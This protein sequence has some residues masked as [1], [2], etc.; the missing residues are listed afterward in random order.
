MRVDDFV[1]TGSELEEQSSSLAS[2]V[3]TDAV[4]A[5]IVG[6]ADKSR[7]AL[8]RNVLEETRR[9]PMGH[10]RTVAE[11]AT[12]KAGNVAKEVGGRVASDRLV[13]SKLGDPS[14]NLISRKNIK[15]GFRNAAI[16]A[17]LEGSEFEDVD[18]Y[19]YRTKAAAKIGRKGAKKVATTAKR[20][21]E[22]KRA[23]K[24]Q[25]GT[26]K[27]KSPA[28]VLTDTDG[29]SGLGGLSEKKYTQKK[30]PVELQRQMQSIRNQHRAMLATNP[31]HGFV[32]PMQSIGAKASAIAQGAAD[33]VG[34][35]L[36][37][38]SGAFAPAVG[39]ALVGLLFLTI[40][41]GAV[42]GSNEGN[43]NANVDGLAETE[44]EIT[45]TLSGYGFTNEAIAAILGNFA[46]ESGG[47]NHIRANTDSDDGYGTVSLGVMQMTGSERT[48]FLQWASKNGKDW[49][50][51]TT[52]MEWAFSNKSGTSSGYFAN[53][54]SYSWG[55]SSWHGYECYYSNER[56]YEHRFKTDCLKTGKDLIKTGD[57]DLAVY[58]WMA[59]YERPGSKNSSRY[60]TDVSRLN[61]RLSYA[62]KYLE[63]INS[64]NTSGGSGADYKSAS[65]AQKKIADQCKKEPS[66][67]KGQCA[68]WTNNVYEHATGKRPSTNANDE[69]FKY[70]KSSNKKD[71]KVGML[72]ASGPHV[73]H[74]GKYRNGSGNST[75]YGHIG[76]Y[77][78]DNKVMHSTGGSVHTDSLD[79]WIKSFTV[80]DV[81]CNKTMTVKWGFPDWVK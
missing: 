50:S 12:D 81:S 58:S 55:S 63:I 19:Y 43:T 45:Q 23:K 35:I 17:A 29:P 40:I 80:K 11:S 28:N 3:A 4:S 48:R 56:G 20:H 42:G 47:F 71:L 37:T 59:C 78:G 39:T 61:N 26:T 8:K 27:K 34:S 62:H 38:L 64:G 54:W 66:T 6:S 77:V 75:G 74:T 7:M 25:R 46:Q 69:Y 52:Q 32:G 49:K 33:G 30:S 36:G 22:K 10:R 14:E 65:K 76:I 72:I 70:C 41:S 31:S 16:G 60:N 13:S 18:T 15:A 73:G 44:T 9:N 68:K 21:S 1:T 5:G 24:G 67:G 79:D 57:V 51:V 53:R 2:N